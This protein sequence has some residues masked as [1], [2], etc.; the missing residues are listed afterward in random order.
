MRQF[1]LLLTLSAITSL[2]AVA[3]TIPR[4]ELFAGYSLLLESEN[5]FQYLGKKLFQGGEVAIG[6]NKN[7]WFGIVLDANAGFAPKSSYLSAQLIEDWRVR[8]YRVNLGPAFSFREN[9]RVTPNFHALLGVARTV[10]SASGVVA[11]NFPYGPAAPFTEIRTENNLSA[12]LG[13]AVDVKATKRLNFRVLQIDYL[14]QNAT[15]LDPHALR[16]SFGVVWCFGKK[17]TLVK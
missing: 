14:W 5:D 10:R 4:F 2:Q 7:K 15:I 11:Q 12:V 9:N 1:L 6:F 13:G 8:Q 17:P 3:Q 16:L